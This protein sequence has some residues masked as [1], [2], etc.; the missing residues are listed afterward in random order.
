MQSVTV[1]GPNLNDQSLGQFHVHAEGCADIARRYGYL[2]KAA[3]MFTMDAESRLDVA[4]TIYD[5]VEDPAST[6]D[7][8]HFAPCVK[9]A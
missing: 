5:F 2:H 6:L 1:L 8:F 4:T 9:L 3:E 7:E